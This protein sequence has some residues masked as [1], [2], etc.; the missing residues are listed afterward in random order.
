MRELREAIGRIAPVPAPVLILG[1]SGTGKELVA[2]EVHRLSGREGP[3]LAINCAAFPENL[4]E[5]ELFGH[6]AG[7]FTGADRM[8][9]GAFEFADKGTLFLDEIGE[10]P[11]SIQAKLLRVLED[12]EVSRVGGNR[13][14]QVSTRV[15]AATNRDP[16][17]EIEAGR[18]RSDLFY[19][20]NV[21]P[22]QVPPLRDRK[23]DVPLLVEH[24][25]A[26]IARRFGGRPKGMSGEALAELQSYDWH[27]NNVRELR[28][29]VERM[30]IATDGSRIEAG[31]VPVEIG[32]GSGAGSSP[33]LTKGG[34]KEQK[35]EA[36]RRIVLEALER[37]DWQI[38]RTAADM[39]LADHSS[40]LKIMRRHD[41]KRP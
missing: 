31:V 17:A 12:S 8:R 1:E 30:V 5:S 11:V 25:L 35:A 18:F 29:I 23:A 14:I 38:T 9:K 3:F 13:T 4:V 2:R 40:L 24:F 41:I 27:R 7:A 34:L 19:R 21:H 37:N 15:V 39:G 26:V 28:N 10:T 16:E 6:E 22:I 36:E 20:L 32:P 33:P